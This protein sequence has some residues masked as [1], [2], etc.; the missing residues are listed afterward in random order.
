MNC[1]MVI[2]LDSG[3]T[4]S[5]IIIHQLCLTVASSHPLNG[6]LSG[7]IRV[8][9]YQKGKTN[10][11]FTEARDSE[12]QWHQLGR[13]QVCTSLQTDNLASTPTLSFYRP[14]ALPATQPTA[15]KH[16]RH[17]WLHCQFNYN[18]SVMFVS[19][20]III[21]QLYFLVKALFTIMTVM[22]LWWLCDAMQHHVISCSQLWLQLWY[23]CDVTATGNKRVYFF[24]WGCTRLQPITVHESIWV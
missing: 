10:L 9:R 12:W 17:Q 4:I 16:W 5:L 19:Y 8:N 21:Y 1:D 23:N 3:F 13:M 15:S 11:D 14:D 7:T 24:L 18:S 6:P 20:I 2:A 22:L